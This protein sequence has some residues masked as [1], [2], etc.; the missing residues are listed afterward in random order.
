MCP[1]LARVEDGR[2]VALSPHEDHPVSQG[3]CCHKGLHYLDVH[4]DEDRPKKPLRRV[5][6]N[7]DGRGRFEETEWDA[8]IDEI[9]VRLREIREKY[10]PDAIGTYVGNPAAFNSAT[11]LRWIGLASKFGSSRHFNSA[12]QDTTN[13]FAAIEAI[14]GSSQVT[15]PDFF[16]SSY[17]LCLG[18]NPAVSHWTLVSMPR[19]LDGIRD[20]VR[21]GGKVRFVNPRHIESASYTTDDVV[22]IKPDTDAFLLAAMLQEIDATVGFDEDIIGRHGK[23]IDGL[24]RF[25]A[26]YPAERVARIVGTDAA[27]IRKLGREFAEAPSACAYMSTGVNQGRQ[28]TIAYWLLN[29]LSFVTGNL[30]RDGGNYFAKGFYPHPAAVEPTP[31]MYFETPFGK[32]RHMYGA[33]PAST[34]SAFIESDVDPIRALIVISANPLLSV[35]GEEAL[36]RALPKLDLMV[37]VDLYRNATGEYA[38]FIL[39]TPDWLERDDINYLANGTQ[40]FPYVQHVD[41]V[42]PPRHG[43]MPEWETLARIERELG[44]ESALDNKPPSY[45]AHNE[46]M[47]ADSGLSIAKLR[48]APLGTVELPQPDRS[49]FF[50]DAVL[51]PDRKIDC[52]PLSFAQIIDR[53]EAIFLELEAEPAGQM[54]LIGLRTNYMM[55]SNLANMKSL[56]RSPVVAENPLHIAPSDANARDLSDGDLVRIYNAYGSLV[57]PILIDE[58]LR[59]GVVALSHGYGHGLTS[60]QTY[61]HGAPGVNANRLAPTGPGSYERISNMAQ[62]SGIPV[63]IEPVELVRHA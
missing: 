27:E 5:S 29:M 43:R 10:G 30:G 50:K 57:T 26:R 55:N 25:I 15:I 35:A 40:V 12:T 11:M 51:S 59:E 61:A 56:K 37:S 2:I 48:D 14:Y 45:H 18:A 22:Q 21:R 46:A 17:M 20:I 24:R 34:M 8:A 36:R 9:G 44:L 49:D 33:L 47:L 63:T 54:K 60:G 13:K 58:T 39:P 4:N 62:M 16:R 31:E 1:L 53:C 32:M 6:R 38:D 19:P 41:A 28:G 7:E 3:F 52:C 23:N 42:V